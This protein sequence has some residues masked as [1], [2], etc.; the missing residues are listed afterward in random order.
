MGKRKR[1]GKKEEYLD[2]KEIKVKII[3]IFKVKFKVRHKN[4]LKLKVKVRHKKALNLKVKV[5]GSVGML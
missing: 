3:Q 1:K 2:F 5:Q 4:L